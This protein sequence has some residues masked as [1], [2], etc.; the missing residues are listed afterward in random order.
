MIM[1]I[2]DDKREWDDL[3]LSVRESSRTLECQMYHRANTNPSS[4]AIATGPVLM[5]NLLMSHRGLIRCGNIA[6]STRPCERVKALEA[7]DRER[8]LSKSR[9]ISLYGHNIHF[10]RC[11]SQRLAEAIL[12]RS[13]GGYARWFSIYIGD[14]ACLDCCLRT[15]AK[16]LEPEDVDLFFLY[17][18]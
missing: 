18:T 13:A 5:A 1:D 10:L 16:H 6:N 9:T 4:A 3:K 14:A 8:L 11:K 17:L 12:V 15:A 2:I 7:G